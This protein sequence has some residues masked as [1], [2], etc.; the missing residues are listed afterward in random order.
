MT[1]PHQ[2]ADPMGSNIEVLVQLSEIRGQLTTFIS[3]V[4]RLDDNY[5][6]LD[7]KVDGLD[8]RVTAI[9]ATRKATPAWWTW[10]PAACTILT[11]AFLIFDRTQ[12]GA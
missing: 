5:N 6:K 2:G 8:N 9:E 1:S 11:V 10:V 4:G 3:V 7:N 12:K